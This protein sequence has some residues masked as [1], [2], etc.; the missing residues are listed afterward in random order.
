MIVKMAHEE[1]LLSVDMGL[2]WSEMGST[3]W[4]DSELFNFI[5]I[6]QLAFVYK[7]IR[8]KENGRE[9]NFSLV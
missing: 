5:S 1:F 7:K 6:P 2:G 3:L 4:L 8:K 9:L